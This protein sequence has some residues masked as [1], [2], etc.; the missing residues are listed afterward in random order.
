[1]YQQ[2]E[3]RTDHDA[4]SEPPPPPLHPVSAAFTGHSRHVA[5]E[6]TPHLLKVPDQHVEFP[7]LVVAGSR[8]FD[9][10]NEVRDAVFRR[11][12]VPQ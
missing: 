1:M 7:Y 11:S 3:Y 10:W 6:L 12:H 4:G 9:R 8:Q 5:T 2:R